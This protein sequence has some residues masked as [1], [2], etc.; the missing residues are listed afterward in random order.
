[1]TVENENFLSIYHQNLT[2]DLNQISAE[3]MRA[4][5]FFLATIGAS[6]I[7]YWYLHSNLTL[8]V[9]HNFIQSKELAHFQEIGY[10]IVCLT[11]NII[12]WLISEYSLS[13]AF[14]FRNIQARL[15]AIEGKFSVPR[16]FNDPT[17]ID[18]FVYYDEADQ[19]NRLVMEYM[20]PD[21]FV[22]IYW[23]STWLLI[24]NTSVSF[25]LQH[26]HDIFKY[27]SI[28]YVLISVPFIWKLWTYYC[29]KLNKFISETCSFKI[30]HK[31]TNGSYN[32]YYNLETFY[33]S[34]AGSTFF[35]VGY[36]AYSFI[37]LIFYKEF[38]FEWQRIFIFF[39]LGWFWPVYLGG[40]PRI[41]DGQ[42]RSHS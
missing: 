23:A 31:T 27:E 38:T 40:C 3:L 24:V 21:Q 6:G 2:D 28:F 16:I 42:R 14:L 29:Y 17:C 13:H 9:C 7:A 26:D 4:K 10:L 39:I 19:K 33:M 18:K 36:L 8:Y 41:A 11:G 37:P 15:I 25:L 34:L 5:W 35:V 12:F 30:I 32:D 20:I 1:M 22:P